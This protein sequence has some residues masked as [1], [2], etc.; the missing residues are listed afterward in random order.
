[1]ELSLIRSL[2]D[3]DFYD[4]HRGARCPN[5]LFSKDVQKIKEAIDAAMF[6]YERTV[7]PAEIQSLFVSSNPTMTTA[8]KQA[9]NT[10]FAKINSQTPLGDDIAQDVLSKLFQQVV[11]EDIAN[12]GFDYVNG[13]KTSLEPLRLLLDKYSDDF[14]PNLTVKWENIDL[15]HIMSLANLET[16]WK[17]NIPSLV[18]KVEGVT[19]GHLIEVGARPN[20][21]KTSFHA[22]IVAGP[23]GFADQGA[24]TVV[25]CNEES[26]HRVVLR[27]INAATN[28]N[29]REIMA[30]FPKALH[31]YNRVKPNILFKDSSTE[32]MDWVESTCKSYK[33]D[34]VVLD[35]GDK[36]ARTGGN[37]RTDEALKANAI[38]ARQ[39]AKQ[40]GCAMFYMSQLNAEAENKVVLNQAMMEGSRTGKAAEADLMILI[41][42]NPSLQPQQVGIP[43]EGLEDQDPIRHLNL[44][45]NKLSGWHGIIHCELDNLTAR[46]TA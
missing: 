45:K 6:R 9:Y 7:T 32:D 27:Y 2:M 11:G 15:E 43:V 3:K 24:K 25:L 17:F 10:L 33:P 14:T 41:A 34:V 22:S 44:V 23:N 8:Q 21:G 1:M 37:I 35:M 13:D 42:K 40:H 29:E 26:Y 5:R 36:F 18:R 16:Q 39:I 31:L 20:T 46:Y 30:D 12:L 19:G 4:E 28:M 38:H